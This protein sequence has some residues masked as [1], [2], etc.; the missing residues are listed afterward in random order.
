MQN[1]QLT[2]AAGTDI[3]FDRCRS[4]LD[5]PSNRRKCALRPLNTRSSMRDNLRD[6]GCRVSDCCVHGQR[7]VLC[8]YRSN[9]QERPERDVKNMSHRLTLVMNQ[10]RS[11]RFDILN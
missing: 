1:V 9:S 5:S 2:V 7:L 8:G 6:V 3:D 4:N 10:R 11:T